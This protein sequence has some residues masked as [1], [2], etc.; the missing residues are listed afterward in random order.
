MVHGEE[1]WGPGHMSGY[2]WALASVAAPQLWLLRSP[3]VPAPAPG[4]LRPPALCT[5]PALSLSLSGSFS[6][7]SASISLAERTLGS[8]PCA[9]ARLPTAALGQDS[10]SGVPSCGQRLGAHPPRGLESLLC[11]GGRVLR[12]P[13]VQDHPSSRRPAG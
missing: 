3:P 4:S 6:A 9:Q 1:S 8:G 5:L 13:H 11:V 7:C 12:S 2:P 10:E